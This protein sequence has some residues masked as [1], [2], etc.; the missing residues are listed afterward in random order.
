MKPLV[1]NDITILVYLYGYD[2]LTQAGVSKLNEAKELVDNLKR[3]AAEQ[4]GILAE[5][6]QEADASLIEITTTMQVTKY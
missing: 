3:R 6:Q 5:K 2:L 1:G 4:S